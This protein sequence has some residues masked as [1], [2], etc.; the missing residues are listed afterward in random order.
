MEDID[1]TLAEIERLLANNRVQDADE[2]LRALISDLGDK[3]LQL[4]EVDV[5]RTIGR[6]F[7]KRRRDLTNSLEKRLR[8]KAPGFAQPTDAETTAALAEVAAEL[9][10]Q[11]SELSNRHIFQWSTY[12]R[13][14]LYSSF[15]RLLEVSMAAGRADDTAAVIRREI[16]SHAKEIFKKGYDY[17]SAVPTSNPSYFLTKS[18]SGLQRFLDLPIEFYSTKTSAAEGVLY[19]RVLR[20]LCSAFLSGIVEGY[21]GVQ[22]GRQLGSQVLPRFP[23][24][25]AHYLGFLTSPDL[26]RILRCLEPGDFLD[27]VAHSVNPLVRALDELALHATDYVPLPS[28]GQILW[29]QRRLDVALRPPPQADDL[30]LIEV[31]C[32]LDPAFVSLS[33]LQEAAN[34]GVALVLAPVRSDLQDHVASNER[35]SRVVVATADVSTQV[36]VVAKRIQDVLEYSIYGRRSPRAAAAPLTYNFAREFPLHNAFLTR[37]FHVHRSSIR[38]LLRTFERRNGAR[39]WCSVR[40]SGKTTACFDLGTTTGASVI[41]SQTC[42]STEQILDA[43]LFYDAVSA[44]LDHGRAVPRTFFSDVVEQCSSGR[45]RSTERYVFVIDE[46][47]TL[48]GRLR[49]AVHRDPELRYTVVQ[50]LLN[51]MVAFTRDNLLVF[52]GQQPNA[53]FILM[54]Q[55]QLSP[56]VEQDPF[57]LFH[58]SEGSVDG[59]FAE[60]VRKI[61]TERIAFGG[62]FADGVFEETSGH[63][64]LTVQVLVAFVDWLIERGRRV[65]DLR[66]SKDDIVEFMQEKLKPRI[67]ARSAEYA[68]FREA[69]AEAISGIGK[70]Q[71]PW[72]YAVYS[73][74]REIVRESPEHFSISEGD[75]SRIVDSLGVE[76]LGLTTDYILGTG[77]QANFFEAYQGLVRPKIRLLGRIAGISRGRTRA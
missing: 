56:Y 29:D 51:Q 77:S 23:R 46:Y 10:V 34:R 52:I 6:F 32:F 25:W 11:L 47:E 44:A 7:P 58:H 53:H 57:P 13:D 30:Q 67:V 22:L 16:A 3:E 37:Y 40:R 1:E 20:T 72:L 69:I 64:F 36:P 41:V 27:A 14:F 31:Q 2:L 28:L 61:L 70:K 42:D 71:N 15:T 59:E 49:T 4:W 74:L 39:L 66:L 26:E 17:V 35:L 55:N 73:I 68:F 75:V 65:R 8:R 5:R 50:P 60:L 62:D 76:E 63:P 24:S 21:C 45:T 43:N 48:F 12:Y 54:D 38:N 33:A 9:Q 18:V 19:A